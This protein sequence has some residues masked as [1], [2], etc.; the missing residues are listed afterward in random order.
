[1]ARIKGTKNLNPFKAKWTMPEKPRLI[2]CSRCG[3][4][5]FLRQVDGSYVHENERDC[6]EMIIYTERRVI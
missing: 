3:K 1:M 2:V 5:G 6:E 4:T